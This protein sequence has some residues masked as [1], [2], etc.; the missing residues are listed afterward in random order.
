MLRRQQIALSGQRLLER[1]HQA[2]VAAGKRG[3][4]LLAALHQPVGHHAFEDPALEPPAV[5]L[6]SSWR[7]AL[8]SRDPSLPIVA[9]IRASLRSEACPAVSVTRTQSAR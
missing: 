7:A 1:R 4:R 2:G 5:R 6:V 3:A 8:S 9:R